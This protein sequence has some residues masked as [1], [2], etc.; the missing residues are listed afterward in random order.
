MKSG[1]AWSCFERGRP[2]DVSLLPMGLAHFGVADDN[3]HEELSLSLRLEAAAT[4]GVLC[5]SSVGPGPTP[6]MVADPWCAA[7]GARSHRQVER[8]SIDDRRFQATP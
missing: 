6:D 8:F 2:L 5:I 3:V 7:Q 4:I 1:K